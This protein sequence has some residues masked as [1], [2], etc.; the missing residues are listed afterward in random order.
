MQTGR[1]RLT[2]NGRSGEKQVPGQLGPALERW[3]RS[4]NHTIQAKYIVDEETVDDACFAC[5]SCNN[6]VSS[7]VLVF[8][9]AV[10]YTYSLA[11]S[12]ILQWRTM[13]RLEGNGAAEDEMGS[14]DQ[15]VC[16]C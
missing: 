7:V 16:V 3:F 15:T 4:T 6:E 14:G 2:I 11:S 9:V 13:L 1:Q 8:H 12:G 10:T 5:R